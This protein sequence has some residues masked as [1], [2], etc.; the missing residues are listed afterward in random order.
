MKVFNL[1]C[2]SHKT[3]QR[4]SCAGGKEFEKDF[5]SYKTSGKGT[6]QFPMDKPMPLKLITKIVKLRV[7]E[8]LEKAKTKKSQAKKLY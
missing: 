7:K 6:I 4:L 3:Y 8:N 1:F 2:Y 5:A